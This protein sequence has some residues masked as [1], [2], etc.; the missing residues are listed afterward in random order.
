MGA[1]RGTELEL[2]NGQDVVIGEGAGRVVVR[3]IKVRGGQVRIGVTAPRT[4]TILRDEL[5][6]KGGGDA[7]GDETER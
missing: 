7:S 2:G 6:R 3:V 4:H 1:A 5:L